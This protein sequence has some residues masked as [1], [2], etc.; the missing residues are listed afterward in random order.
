MLAN[1]N[2]RKAISLAFDKQGIATT[3]LNNGSIPANAFVP[4][5][6]SSDLFDIY[7]QT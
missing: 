2:A 5:S 4:S 3:I 1:K 7:Q 6:L